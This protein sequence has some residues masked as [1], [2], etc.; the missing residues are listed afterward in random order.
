MIALEVIYPSTRPTTNFL[1]SVASSVP[2]G[3]SGLV[4]VW[5]R[6]DMPTN[7]KLGTHWVVTDPDGVVVED[8]SDWEAWSTGP[9]DDHHFIGD[10]FDLDKEGTYTIAISLFMNPDSPV[11]VDSYKGDLC[12]ATEVPPVY[13]LVYQHEYPRGKT[14]VG[15]A[16]E[17]T[18]S[19][20]INLPE[21]L[22]P[23][24]WVREKIAN[25]FAE[26]VEEEGVQMLDIKIYEDATPTWH[27]DYKIVATATASPIPWAIIIPLVLVIILV[28]AFTNLVIQVKD[29]DWGE[30]PPAIPWAILALAGGL[31]VVGGGAA[32][33]LA[34]ARRE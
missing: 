7:Q 1:Q 17:C 15:K 6:N 27:T 28:I 18:A 14:Y 33:A 5:G 16:E 8:Y 34:T 30:I 31:V 25:A 22:F 32:I 10:R 12:T 3:Q 2:I 4:H 21:Q 20:T 24:G 19:L 29:I 23:S 9:G 11:I 26:K 13:E